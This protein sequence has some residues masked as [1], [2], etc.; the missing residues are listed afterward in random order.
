VRP[1]RTP[2]ALNLNRPPESSIRAFPHSLARNSGRSLRVL[3]RQCVTQ[4]G[5]WLPGTKAASFSFRDVPKL[6]FSSSG[7]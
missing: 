4:S 6:S 1:L 5:Q 2:P 3:D 7:S